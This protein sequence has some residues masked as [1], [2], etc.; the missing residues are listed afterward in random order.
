GIRDLSMTAVQTCAL[1]ISGS[2]APDPRP[3]DA[4]R[5]P[6]GSAPPGG[7]QA[8]G[9]AATDPGDQPGAGG[10]D[11]PGQGAGAVRFQRGSGAA[12]A[13]SEERRVGERY[14]AEPDN[15]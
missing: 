9:R 8:T 11:V 7:G 15:G 2:G 5:G 14:P 12:G 10:G 3:R 4:R 1:R 13:R 6:A